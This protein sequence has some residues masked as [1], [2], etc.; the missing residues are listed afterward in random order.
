LPL[1]APKNLFRQR[2]VEVVRDGELAGAEAE[3]TRTG[4]DGGD[5]PQLSDRA[6]AADHE[7]ALPGFNPLQQGVGVPSKLL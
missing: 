4:R 7:E 2:C 3:R 6:T 1:E 5:G